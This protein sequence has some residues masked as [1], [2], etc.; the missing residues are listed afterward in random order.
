MTDRQLAHD[1]YIAATCDAVATAGIKPADTW[2][3]DAET[4]GSYRY[5]SATIT[6]TPDESG[7]D[8]DRFPHGLLLRWEWHTGLEAADGEPERGP[9][10]LWQKGR[11]DGSFTEPQTLTADGYA[12]PAVVA[13]AAAALA[14]DRETPWP[15]RWK[16]AHTLDTSCQT[17][18]ATEAGR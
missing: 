12:S 18:G 4:A 9:V 5:L 2:T 17:W 13:A 3:S 10:W 16:H 6:L 8:P 1:S 15:D 14:D 7:I 11:R